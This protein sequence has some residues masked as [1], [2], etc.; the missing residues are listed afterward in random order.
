MK[1]ALVSLASALLAL[2][3]VVGLA[4][5]SKPAA[6]V[7]V[8]AKIQVLKGTDENAKA[9]ALAALAAAGPAS[10]PAVPVLIELLKSDSS[11]LL[12]KSLSAYALGQIG[13]AA[14]P[15]IP[16]LKQCM[17]SG[18][19]DLITASANAIGAIDPNQ[20]PRAR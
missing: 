17:Q 3:L 11:A 15:A 7:D 16:V 12:T 19:R 6:K 18:E 13:P 5:C 9:D 2:A 10:A 4:G 20:S 14:A 8:Q 1:K